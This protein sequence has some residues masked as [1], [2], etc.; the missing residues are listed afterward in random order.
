MPG[1]ILIFTIATTGLFSLVTIA[2]LPSWG[3]NFKDEDVEMLDVI[4][5][6]GTAFKR[7]PR[8]L[9]FPTPE[10]DSLGSFSN[11]Q[12]IQIP[13][14]LQIDHPA[15]QPPRVMDPIGKSRGIRSSVKPIK[16]PRP[17]YPRFARE[18]GWEGTAM[19]RVAVEANGSV[20]K[21][22]IQKSSGFSI[23]D[24]SALQAVKQWGFAPAKNGEF[25]VA[26]I[27]DIPIRFDLNQPSYSES[28]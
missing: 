14:T 16:V 6:P 22:T 2:T 20:S 19:L 18:Q 17:S 25:S 7:E 28:K 15:S 1:W 11:Q 9:L 24:E 26:A 5:V 13:L 12:L 4:E 10:I 27:V 21:A 23:L 3:Q 8:Q